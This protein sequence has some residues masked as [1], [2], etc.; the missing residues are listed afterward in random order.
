MN[1]S[2]FRARSGDG[3]E[4]VI[5]VTDPGYASAG[6]MGD[7]GKTIRKR[8]PTLT[9]DDGEPVSPVEGDEGAFRLMDRNIVVRRVD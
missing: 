3:L 4:V 1:E 7:P 2:R 9:T 5:V 8:L 6:H